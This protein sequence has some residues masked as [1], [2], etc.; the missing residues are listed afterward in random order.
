MIFSFAYAKCKNCGDI[1]NIEVDNFLKIIQ[2][3]FNELD[4]FCEICNEY[5]KVYIDELFCIFG[6]N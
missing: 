3:D 6:S 2:E 5:N 1:L 4:I